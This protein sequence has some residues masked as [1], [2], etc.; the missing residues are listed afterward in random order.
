MVYYYDSYAIIETIKG[1]EK[2]E[3]YGL[4]E[5]ITTYYNV[6]EVFYSLLRE[7]G[8]KPAQ[9]ALEILSPLIVQPGITD[10]EPSMKLKNRQKKLSYI[11][12]LGYAIAKRLGVPFL[13]GDAAF[14]GMKNVRYVK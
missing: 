14:K 3:K 10:I 12:A 6:L 13:T 9:R 1:N 8:L 7:A 5:G 11:D 2:Y 4:E